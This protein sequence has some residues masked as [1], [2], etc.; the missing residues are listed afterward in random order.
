[1]SDTDSRFHD[2]KVN[3]YSWYYVRANSPLVCCRFKSRYDFDPSDVRFRSPR[4]SDENFPKN[5]ELVDK[6]RAV[7]VKYS[8]S[9]GQITLAWIIAEN[10]DFV[11]IPGSRSIERL[12]ENAKAGEIVLDPK[13]VQA[14]RE[15]VD[16]MGVRGERSTEEAKKTTWTESQ[17]P[18]KIS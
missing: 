11:P 8:A 9:T 3:S 16:T 12:E 18:E 7:A 2:G 5:L 17:G 1:M 15:I 6:F 4:M 14:L 13:D 10:P